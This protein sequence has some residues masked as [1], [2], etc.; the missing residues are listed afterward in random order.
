MVSDKSR[1]LSPTSS[2][3]AQIAGQGGARGSSLRT[4]GRYEIVSELGRAGPAVILDARTAGS[5]ELVQLKVLD[6]ARIDDAR[7]RTEEWV[8][9]FGREVAIARKL[10]H[11]ALPRLLEAGQEGPLQYIAYDRVESVPLSAVIGRGKPLDAESI[12]RIIAGV[13][14]ALAYLH[15]RGFVCCNVQAHSVVLTREGYARVNDLSLAASAA[16]PT[17]PLLS[18]NTFV[19]TP[20]YLNGRGYGPESDQFAL[21]ALL[22]ELL[23]HTRPFRGL[24]DRTLVAAIH[25]KAPIPPQALDSRVN[26]FLSDVAMRT[27]EKEPADRFPSCEA[28]AHY[29]APG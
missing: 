11:R 9:C 24:D 6:T 3:A 20:E 19:L 14:Q 12:R 23:T 17:H 13:A 28:L 4:I 27:L 2:G 22:Y 8:A 1:D 26:P 25:D 10:S 16:G 5:N 15:E 29:L 21:G 7:L 18:H